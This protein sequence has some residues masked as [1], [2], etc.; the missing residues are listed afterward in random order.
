MRIVLRVNKVKVILARRNKTFT[1][2]A[3]KIDTSPQYVS[4]LLAQKKNPSPV[5]RIK[6][7]RTLNNCRWDDLFEIKRTDETITCS[8]VR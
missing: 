4:A 5:T 1:W 7:Q 2:L 6:I 8:G 3:Q